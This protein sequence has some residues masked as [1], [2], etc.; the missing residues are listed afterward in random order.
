MILANLENEFGQ[1]FLF[2]ILAIA[3]A[4][5]FGKKFLNSNPEVKDAAKQAATRKI[6]EL[7]L[8]IGKK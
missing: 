6:V 7:F 4:I 2:L 1:M 3:T 8:K 5:H